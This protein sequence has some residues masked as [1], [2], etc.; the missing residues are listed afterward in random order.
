M[1]VADLIENLKT[2]DPMKPIYIYLEGQLYDI[3]IDDAI[4]DR[5]DLMLLD[6]KD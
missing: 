1:K 3:D 6:I 4:S 2:L 5:V